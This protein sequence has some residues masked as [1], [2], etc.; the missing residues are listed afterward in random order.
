MPA[1]LCGIAFSLV[2][3]NLTGLRPNVF[4]LRSGTN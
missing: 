3:K 1:G 2:C 4:G